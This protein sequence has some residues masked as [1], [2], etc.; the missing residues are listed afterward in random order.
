MLQSNSGAAN[1][2][3]A[4][5]A[6]PA[7]RAAQASSWVSSSQSLDCCSPAAHLSPQT[8]L[9]RPARLG[10][11]RSKWRAWPWPTIS[12]PAGAGGAP[13]QSAPDVNKVTI[14]SYNINICSL[15]LVVSDDHCVYEILVR[16][17]QA[18]NF[19]RL[20]K[21]TYAFFFAFLCWNEMIERNAMMYLGLTL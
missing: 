20:T 3:A 2:P 6:L 15:S 1:C 9:Y 7:A 21:L 18:C 10:N 12:W 13:D 19:I 17:L 14:R 5:A 8:L 4:D 11:Q 16:V